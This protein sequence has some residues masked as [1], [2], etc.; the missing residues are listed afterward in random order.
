MDEYLF[1]LI[2]TSE[3]KQF[4]LETTGNTLVESPQSVSGG[5]INE[6]YKLV[7]QSSAYCLKCNPAAFAKEMFTTE[8]TGL[9]LLDVNSEFRVP[10]RLGIISAGQYHGLLLEWIESGSTKNDFW[11]E[12]GRS[13]AGLHRSTHGY[14]G[15]ETNNF[16][17]TIPQ[18]NKQHGSWVSFYITERLKPLFEM[19]Y[20]RNLFHP[21]DA[22]DIDRLYTKLD[23]LIPIEAPALLHG[24]LWSGNY[25]CD[26]NGCPVLID[27][28][29]Y[30]GHREID[31][32]MTKL[33]GGF[34]QHMYNA[35]HESFPLAA[36]WQD[37]IPLNQLYP[38]L[39]HVNLFGGHYVHQV[40]AV[41]QR[42]L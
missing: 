21:G 32:A 27:P 28:A 23:E 26:D 31:L 17:G 15:L 41:I 37:R 1:Y 8:L 39:V 22:R 38:L 13:L 6:V 36:G 5:D 12:F 18:S 25:M 42:Y 34:G 30:Y 19:A 2:S 20:D 11:E 4:L 24:D 7:T 33:F 40:R 14:F 16:I 29:V 10:K 3:I 9:D 35:Y